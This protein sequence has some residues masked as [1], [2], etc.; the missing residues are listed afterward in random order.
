MSQILKWLCDSKTR[1]RTLISLIAK[2]LAITQA[3]LWC[4]L[5]F[6][7]L[8]LPSSAARGRL[9][10]VEEG[11]TPHDRPC[12]VVP[13]TLSQKG[14]VYPGSGCPCSFGWLWARLVGRLPPAPTGRMTTEEFSS[15]SK[16]LP[17]SW[18]FSRLNIRWLKWKNMPFFYKGSSARV[19]TRRK[20]AKQV[21]A[22][23]RE[24]LV[25]QS[26]PTVHSN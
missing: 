6:C 4:L 16:V 14:W 25:W 7:C 2:F 13:R 11:S 8:C 20:K 22:R 1:L 21:S 26:S 18:N 10:V 19:Q 17:A 23:G 5:S 15:L 9:L 3:P 24:F 12:L